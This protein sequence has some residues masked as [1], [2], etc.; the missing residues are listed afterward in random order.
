M[1]LL[2]YGR[3]RVLEEELVGV[4]DAVQ[5]WAGK[6]NVIPGHPQSPKQAAAG[7]S[8]AYC[9]LNLYPSSFIGDNSPFWSHQY[10]CL[11]A[12]WVSKKTAV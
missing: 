9:S 7:Y 6:V 1:Y 8:G 12:T 10:Q 3:T 4:A 5:A 2:V 11:P